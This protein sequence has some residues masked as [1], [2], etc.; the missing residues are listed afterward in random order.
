[1]NFV[2]VEKIRYIRLGDG[3]VIDDGAK[4]TPGFPVR[5]DCGNSF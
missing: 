3:L 4:I 2:E 1:M 5:M